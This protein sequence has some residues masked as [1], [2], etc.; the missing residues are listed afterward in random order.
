MSHHNARLTP[1]GRRIIIER[2]LSGRPVAHVAKEIG[3]SRTCAHRWL[4]RYRVHGWAGDRRPVRGPGRCRR[5]HYPGLLNDTT[6]EAAACPSGPP[7]VPPSSR[8]PRYPQSPRAGSVR[9]R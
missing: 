2:V 9:P 8:L 3:I 4:S 6:P 1:T 5:R 7:G